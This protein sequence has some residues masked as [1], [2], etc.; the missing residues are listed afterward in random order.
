MTADSIEAPFHFVLP[1]QLGVILQLP[2]S[3]LAQCLHQKPVWRVTHIAYVSCIK[4]SRVYKQEF[5]D[6]A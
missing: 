6:Y 3:Y 1:G 4:S 2:V 5:N